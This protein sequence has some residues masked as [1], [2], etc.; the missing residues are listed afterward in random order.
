MIRFGP[1]GNSDVFYEGKKTRSSLE[2]PQWLFEQGL[3][4][5]EY[6][7]SRGVVMKEETAIALG[8][9]AKKYNIEISVHAPYYINLAGTNDD[10]LEKSYR[11]ILDCLKYLKLLGGKRCIFHPGTCGSLPRKEAFELLKERTKELMKRV[12][13]AG[14]TDMYIC[15]ETMGKSQQLGTYEEIAEI[16]T[17]DDRLLPTIDFG[18]INALE[19]GSLK[20]EE[21]FDRVIS[22]L[23]SRLGIEKVK[24]MHIHFSKIEYGQKGEIKHLTFDDNVYGPE[25]N[26]LAKVLKKYDLEPIIICESKGT[27][28]IDANIMKEI[29]KNT[30]I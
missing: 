30:T 18:H 20:T 7:F 23:I 28:S 25:F 3:S 26:N 15:P 5:Y 8:E 22:Y 14:Y 10:L 11:Y 12:R 1:A 27:Q 6:S 21:D 2:A 9:E 16:C 13:E 4:A 19:Q 17:Y 29:Y 24:K